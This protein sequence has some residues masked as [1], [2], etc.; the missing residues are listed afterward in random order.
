MAK[1]KPKPRPGRAKRMKE[2]AQLP[3]TEDE[4]N[5]IVHG[6]AIRYA[7]VRDERCK[8]TK[9]EKEAKTDLIETMKENGL[10]RYQYRELTVD[11]TNNAD[12]KVK[13]AGSETAEEGD[14]E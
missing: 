10:T 13:V 7:E 9:D 2:Q 8:L 11:L 14:G 5:P 6:K 1:K 12:V 4:K 3:G